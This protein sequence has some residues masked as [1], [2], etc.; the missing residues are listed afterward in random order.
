MNT[1]LALA[2]SAALA[3]A[4]VAFA[5]TATDNTQQQPVQKKQW[6][7]RRGGAAMDTQQRLDRLSK[8]LNLSDDQKA[9]IK[10]ILDDEQKQMKA[11]HDDTATTRQDKTAKMKDLHQNTLSQ[12]RPLLNADQ[13][14][15]FDDMQTKQQARM[16]QHM[17]NHQKQNST[18]TQQQ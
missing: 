14:K 6:H 18:A 8:R 1:R 13:Q 2:L 7:G 12:I 16:Q 3:L 11:L 4:P 5:Q 10:P 9:K 15:Q 17:A